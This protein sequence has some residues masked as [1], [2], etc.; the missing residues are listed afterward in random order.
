MLA[1]HA[2]MNDGIF[3][4]AIYFCNFATARPQYRTVRSVAMER[5]LARSPMW[6]KVAANY[7]TG[8]YVQ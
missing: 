2:R 8:P 1:M 4:S 3:A 5:L 6:S 7:N